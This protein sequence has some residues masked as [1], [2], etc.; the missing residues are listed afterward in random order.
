MKSRDR[1]LNAA[2]TMRSLA[3]RSAYNGWID[4][5]KYDEIIYEENDSRIAILWYDIGMKF[6]K[7]LIVFAAVSAAALVAGAEEP[8]PE[9]AKPLKVLMIGNSFSVCNLHYMPSVAKNL[10]CKL[11]LCNLYIGGCTFDRHAGNLKTSWPQYGVKWNYEGDTGTNAVPF[12]ALLSHPKEKSGK[13]KVKE[14]KGNLRKMI[15]ADKWDIVTIQQGSSHSWD[16]SKYQPHA[17]KLIAA[18][19]ELAP[20]AEIR[21]QQTWSYCKADKRICNPANGLAGTWGFDRR[22]MYERLTENYNKLAAANGFKIIPTGLAIE[23]F[24]A[25]EKIDGW[26]GDLVGN[27]RKTKNGPTGDPIHLNRNGEF[28]QGLV[29]TGAIFGVDITKCTYVPDGMKPELAAKIRAAA[30]AVLEA[31]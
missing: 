6:S 29:W 25:A 21:I 12:M 15:A 26:E 5:R 17:D 19:K 8:K 13:E 14:W 18:V 7:A 23:N 1:R 24:R 30:A 10:G 20:Q 16:W 3:G 28:L 31:R 4:S 11:D 27:I 2:A 22:G 9:T